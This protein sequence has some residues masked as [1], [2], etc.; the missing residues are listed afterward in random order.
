MWF[1]KYLLSKDLLL[2][3]LVIYLFLEM[4]SYYVAQAGVLLTATILL[5][6]SREVLTC[7]VS[8]LDCFTP[9]QA[10]W[11]SPMLMLNLA[12]TPDWHSTLPDWHS[13][14]PEPLGSSDS[15]GSVFWVSGTT[16]ICHCAW[17][18]FF[19]IVR[20]AWGRTVCGCATESTVFGVERHTLICS[21]DPVAAL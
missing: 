21:K 18:I 4:G 12:W 19:L 6:I 8:N 16:D 5:L 3:V 14:V 10:L 20:M 9:P 15:P 2:C 1:N 7:S 13:T 11:W 17:Q